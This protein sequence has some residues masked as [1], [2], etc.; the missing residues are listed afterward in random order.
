[1]DS[2]GSSPGRFVKLPEREV[3]NSLPCGAKI[4][5]C[6]VLPHSPKNLNYLMLE[7]REKEFT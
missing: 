6:G 3:Y 5:I 7:Q 2:V 1:M 4:R